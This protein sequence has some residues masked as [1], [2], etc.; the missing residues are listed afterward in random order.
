LILK[1]TF[2][3]GKLRIEVKPSHVGRSALGVV[4]ITLVAA[5]S[6]SGGSP[7]A[8][9]DATDQGAG[10]TLIAFTP[11]FEGWRTW[12]K[13]SLGEGSAQ[14]QA[15]LA[16]PRTEYLNKRPPKGSTAFPVGTI[17]VKELEVGTLGDRKV[18]AMVK[19]GGRLQR[20]QRAGLGVVRAPQPARRHDGRHRVAR[21]RSSRR[22]AI[23]RRQDGVR[24]LPRRR[25][26][27]RPRRSAGALELLIARP[28]DVGLSLFA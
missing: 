3:I 6:D 10:G 19:R 22:R 2:N 9:T 18:F 5:C 25:Q 14:G 13:F 17:I 26:R 8:G 24:D 12:E 21:L 28:C 16:G 23:R 11:A 15:H 27:L 20:R 1:V 7:T 4:A